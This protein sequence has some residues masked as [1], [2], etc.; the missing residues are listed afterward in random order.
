MTDQQE[1]RIGHV[2]FILDTIPIPASLILNDDL[3]LQQVGICC[4]AFAVGLR[5]AR[6]KGLIP[7]AILVSETVEAMG[8]TTGAAGYEGQ[9]ENVR[10]AIIKGFKMPQTA[11][12]ATLKTD[13]TKVKY[14]S[15]RQKTSDRYEEMTP[16]SANNLAVH[17]PG[18]DVSQQYRE[19]YNWY[20]KH[21]LK[22]TRDKFL[23]WCNRVKPK[24]EGYRNPRTGQ[25]QRTMVDCEECANRGFIID[26]VAG[27][28]QD[29]DCPKCQST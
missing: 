5:N 18:I 2:N 16:E 7:F 14:S 25:L 11:L 6:T 29:I 9:L 23:Q 26:V 24:S 28:I 12:L 20:D 10:D 17:F 27:E 15:V 8:Y 22:L 19:A 21:H 4:I 1:V 3:S 13:E